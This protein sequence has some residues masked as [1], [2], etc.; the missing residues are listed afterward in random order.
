MK[1]TSTMVSRDPGD[2]SVVLRVL[3]QWVDT[4]EEVTRAAQNEPPLGHVQKEA[5]GSL[6]LLWSV[7]RGNGKRQRFFTHVDQ[8]ESGVARREDRWPL[9]RLGPGVWDVSTS[10]FVEG[11]VHA[12]VTLVNVPEPPPWSLT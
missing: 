11:Q 7:P 10:I 4:P 5:E 1:L 12:F 9:M 6:L 2:A 3:L 8:I